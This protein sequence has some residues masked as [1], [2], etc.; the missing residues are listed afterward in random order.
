MTQPGRRR[1][2]LRST[3]WRLAITLVITQVVT[4]AVGLAIMQA[5]TQRTLEYQAR[6]AAEV[7]GDDLLVEHHT[8]GQRALVQAMAAR[9]ASPDDR[10]FVAFLRG[11]DGARIAG[12]LDTW[13]A[14]ADR[15]S[16]W[17][18]ADL[19]R[20]GSGRSESVGYVVKALPSGE[21]LLTGEV[22]EGQAQV[23]RASEKSFVYALL[24][25]LLIAALASWAIL[26][27]LGRRIDVFSRA[28][29]DIASGRLNTRIPLSSAGDAFDRL[30]TA[31]NAMFERIE[32]LVAEL[33]AVTDSMAHDLR[34]PV[35]R[36]R[37]ALE[38]SLGAARDPR[39]QAAL[40]DAIDEADG[41]QRLLD[42]ALEISR[43]EAGLG[44]SQFERFDLAELLRDLA[45]VYGPLAEDEG[46]RIDVAAP[47][48][49]PVVAHR[50]LLFRAVSNLVDNALKYAV[51]GSA[52]T[53]AAHS[54]PGGMAT[55]DVRDDG[56]GIPTAD[57][58]EALRRFG[59]L[60]PARTRSGAGLGMALVATIAGLHGGEVQLADNQPRG[61]L[62]RL[63][64]PIAG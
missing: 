7:A 13:P 12:N 28:A 3:T 42:T 15:P 52:I 63:T 25:G 34:S 9:I 33:R 20:S 59:R 29:A 37:S 14:A 57:R 18:V 62:V 1:S 5:Q 10:N 30:G 46:F 35:A 32:A 48:V 39:A 22:L 26:R 43:T 53:L 2:L 40:V 16:H 8:G 61:L 47:P 64:L 4:L 27:V 51:G 38:R 58:E 41:L 11:E 19:S 17:T 50:E 45:E 44:R 21:L 54:G 56:P 6:A 31:I 23:T 49:L 36:M 55:L 24:A 60:D